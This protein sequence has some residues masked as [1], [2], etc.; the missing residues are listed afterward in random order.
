MGEAFT[1]LGKQDPRTLYLKQG[2]NPIRGSAPMPYALLQYHRR[3]VQKGWPVVHE[4]NLRCQ[5]CV[6]CILKFA[7][8]NTRIECDRVRQNGSY[9]SRKTRFPTSPAQSRVPIMIRSGFRK[10]FTASPSLR[11][12]GFEHTT[13]GTLASVAMSSDTRSLVPTGTVDF[14][15]ITL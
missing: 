9:N 8:T 1:S 12:S 3:P 13:K 14:V 6:G 15:R 4:A 11:N 7:G 5:E 10:S 2:E